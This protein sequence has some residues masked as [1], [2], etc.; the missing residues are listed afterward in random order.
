MPERDGWFYKDFR[1]MAEKCGSLPV[2]VELVYGLISL[3]FVA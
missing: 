3:L 1:Q 2:Y